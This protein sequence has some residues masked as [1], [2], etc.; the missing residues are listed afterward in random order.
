MYR[1]AADTERF[2]ARITGARLTEHLRSSGFVVV[3][4]PPAAASLVP[5]E[6]S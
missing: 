1:P 4:W 3:K 5:E 2:A 6:G